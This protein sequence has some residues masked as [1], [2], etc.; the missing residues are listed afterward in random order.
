VTN[1]QGEVLP[2][3]QR[4]LLQTAASH[5]G[6]EVAKATGAAHASRRVSGIGWGRAGVLGRGCGGREGEGAG[7]GGRVGRQGGGDGSFEAGQMA[8][9]AS[10]HVATDGLINPHRAFVDPWR[11]IQCALSYGSKTASRRSLW[12]CNCR[13][14]DISIRKGSSRQRNTYL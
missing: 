6:A 2:R 3:Q 11:R 9:C 4:Q 12:L 8:R 14:V 10:V 5:G 13:I 7:W 1:L